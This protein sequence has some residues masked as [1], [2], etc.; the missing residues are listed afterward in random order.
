MDKFASYEEIFRMR[1]SDYDCN[2]HLTPVAILD[3]AQD[4]AGKHADLLNIGFSDLMK[5][6]QIWVLVR[7]RLKVYSYPPLY[8]KIKVKTWPHEKGRVDFDRDT[9]IRDENNNLIAKLESKW[10]IVNY[11]DR[12]LILPRNFSYPIKEI[13]PDINFTTPFNKLE[14]FDISNIKPIELTSA[15]LDLDHNGHVNNIKCVQFIMN[16]VKLEKNEAIDTLEINYVHE[17][18]G[19]EKFK[20]YI[21]RKENIIIAK[22]IRNEEDIFLCKIVLRNI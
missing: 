14:N 6:N 13:C 2:N 20:L 3:V 16:E 9:L 22:A 11:I 10:V 19:F 7:T 5:K 12:K 18:K 8:A 1:I 4:V 17:L 15:F 21:S